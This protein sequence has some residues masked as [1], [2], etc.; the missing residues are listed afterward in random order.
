MK[1]RSKE[2]QVDPDKETT[3][4]IN[5]KNETFVFKKSRSDRESNVNIFYIV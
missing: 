3:K 2:A 1:S 4:I 5:L